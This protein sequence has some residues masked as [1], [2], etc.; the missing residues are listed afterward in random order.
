MD[1]PEELEKYLGRKVWKSRI[2]TINCNPDLWPLFVKSLE[3][4]KFT[5]VVVRSTKDLLP[6]KTKWQSERGLHI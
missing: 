5:G 2:N 1:Y 4:K 3:D 6:G